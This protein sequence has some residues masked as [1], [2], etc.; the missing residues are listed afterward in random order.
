MLIGQFSVHDIATVQPGA[1]LVEAGR[2]LRDAPGGV[3]AVVFDGSLLGTVSMRDLALKGCAEGLDPATATVNQVLDPE[4]PVCA[5]D[6]DLK[7]AL[8]LMGE[9]RQAWLVLRDATDALAGV[10]SL[11]ELLDLLADRVPAE[12]TGPE[13]EYVHRV[14]GDSAS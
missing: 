10:V 8:R 4:P 5:V 13:P 2:V 3:A 9:H 11:A 6:A 7:H 1:T 14:R 12:S